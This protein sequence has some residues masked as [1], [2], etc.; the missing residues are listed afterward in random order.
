MVTT[1]VPTPLPVAKGKRALR[2]KVAL[3]WTWN[4]PAIHLRKVKVG[5]MPGDT[6]ADHEL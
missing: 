2:I 6:E 4:G 5:T 1:P 3:A